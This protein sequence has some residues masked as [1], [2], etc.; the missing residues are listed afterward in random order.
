MDMFHKH[1]TNATMLE[2]VGNMTQ[3]FLYCE[4][5]TVKSFLI[6]KSL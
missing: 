3:N 5:V 4:E 6:V 1:Y 2:N